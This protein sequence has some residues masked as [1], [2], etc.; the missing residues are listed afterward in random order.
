MA[1]R[2]IVMNN[3]AFE[4]IGTPL[5]IYNKPATPFVADFIDKTP[6]HFCAFRGGGPCEA[7][8]SADAGRGERPAP[9]ISLVQR[10]AV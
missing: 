1:D 8:L 10:T 6:P 2:I 3:A 5:E 7:R 4:Q 9:A